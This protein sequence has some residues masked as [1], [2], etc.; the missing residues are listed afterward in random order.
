MAKRAAERSEKTG[1][2]SS[3]AAALERYFGL[4]EQGTDVRTEFIA[5]LTTFLTMVYIVFVNPSILG[6]TGMDTGAVFVATCVAAAVSTMVMALYANYPIALAPGMGINAFFAFTVVL[7]YKYSWQQALAAVFCSG[8]IF[9]LISVLRI[10]Q[11]V[12]DSIPHN[13]KLAVSAGVGLFLGIIALEEAKIVVAHP[14][15]LVTLGDLRHW[16]PVLMLFGFV[17]IAALNYRRIMGGTLIGI[18]V[19]ALIGIP[20]GLTHYNGIVSLPPSIEPTLLKLDF[21]RVLEGTFLIVIFSILFIDV[22]DNAGTLIGVTHRTGLMKDGKLARMKEALISDSFAAMFGAVIGTS[23]T[24]SYIESAAGV[25]A[26]GRTGLTAAVVA[27]LF[28]LALFFSPLAGM[29][30]AYAT[31]A[32]LFYVACVMARGLAEIDWEDITEYAPAVV[33]AV[34]MPLT[35]SIATGI[36]LGF[37]TYAVVKLFAGRIKEASP[38]VVVLAILFAIKFA[39]TGG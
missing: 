24:T 22:F 12:I 19:V 38:A 16:E 21:S 35:Y 1:S 30:P 28:L 6:K 7:T 17:L 26:G 32:A 39:V 36:G 8:V 11:Y 15:T 10:R 13:L 27:V 33:A 25:A 14:A 34:T 9:F 18:L 3:A 2:D 5:G 37:I 29:I 23:T 20:L 4:K 31:A